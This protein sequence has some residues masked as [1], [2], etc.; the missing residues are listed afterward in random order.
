[1]IAMSGELREPLSEEQTRL[2][3]AIYE[4]FALSGEWPIWQYVDLTL[5]AQWELDAATVFASLPVVRRPY[6]ATWSYALTWYTNPSNLP[7]PDQ[8]IALTVAGLRHLPEAAPL[9]EAFLSTVIYLVEQQRKLVPSARAVVDATVTNEA[10]AGQLL[11]LEIDTGSESQVDA[12][13]H[14]L[15]Q[16]LDHEPILWS[17]VQQTGADGKQWTVRVPAALRAL[18][19]IATIDDYLDRVVE[20][21][22]P[23]TAR[24]V[25]LSVGA[26]DLPYAIGYLDAVWMS[27][28]HSHLFVD[29]DAAS[30]ARLT[31]PCANEAEFN[32]LMS[33][34]ADILGH[35][36]PPGNTTPPQRGALEALREHLD[37]SLDPESANR[38]AAA[39]DTLIS[40]RHIRV[41]TQHGDA[42]HRAV[43]AFRQIGLSF[44]PL[45]WP[46]AWTQ[47]AVL[48]RGAL[49]VLREEIHAGLRRG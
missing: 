3:R 35:V 37:Q 8:T 38:T 30:V 22:S 32:S 28:T 16:L 1:M 14:K 12:V 31:Q 20:W 9:L 24:S 11:T 41:G 26:L 6:P 36:V 49:D 7:Q 45:N 40:V 21:V 17:G 27:R 25:T 29:L 33:A 44:P 19:G 34:L 15:R 43:A 39:V 4:P 2:I 23:T 18:R 10:I 13:V 42:R 47:V 5:D 48:A 46:Q